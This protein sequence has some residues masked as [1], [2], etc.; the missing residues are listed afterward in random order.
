VGGGLPHSASATGRLS[1]T[2]GSGALAPGKQRA[3]GA[4][5]KVGRRRGR[6]EG[7]CIRISVGL[8]V[9]DERLKFRAGWT[10]IFY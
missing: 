7:E 6:S 1:T 2:T 3:G 10:Q 4:S 5:G 8:S 9:S